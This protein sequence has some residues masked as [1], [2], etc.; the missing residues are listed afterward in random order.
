YQ[1]NAPTR[2]FFN[3]RSEDD[4]HSMELLCLRFQEMF[5]EMDDNE[6]KY[7]LTK[8]IEDLLTDESPKRQ[9]Y[10][11]TIDRIVEDAYRAGVI[12]ALLMMTCQL[13]TC[14]F[15]LKHPFDSSKLCRIKDNLRLLNYKGVRYFF[16]QLYEKMTFV[17]QEIS[18]AQREMLTPL[19][20]LLLHIMKRDSNV[21]PA[22][23]VA[24]EIN[25]MTRQRSL[26]FA[27]VMETAIQMEN[28]FRPLAEL[29]YVTARTYLF[30]IP[31]HPSFITTAPLWKLDPTCAF[32][33]HRLHLPFRI[34]LYSPQ[35]YALLMVMRQQKNKDAFLYQNMI[36]QTVASTGG[37]KAAL[38]N[39]ILFL[40]GDAMLYMER[41][42]SQS[43]NVS[44]VW[45]N[46]TLALHTLLHYQ[47]C[48]MNRF[49][50][51]LSKTVQKSGCRRAR[52]EVMWTL[53]QNISYL[54]R[55][56]P[57][58]KAS[59]AAI[60]EIYSYL[61]DKEESSVTSS[62]CPLKMVRSLSP[63][64]LWIDLTGGNESLPPP[65]AFLARQIEFITKRDPSEVPTDAMLAVIVNA[66]IKD[67]TQRLE[68]KT[69]MD[70]LISQLNAE[71]VFYPGEHKTIAHYV[72]F[73]YELLA[74]LG[75]KG[76]VAM[77]QQLLQDMK[78][79]TNDPNC[80]LPSP[81]MIETAARLSCLL[82]SDRTLGS[83]FARFV[84]EQRVD[85]SNFRFMYI[86]T[87][88][89]TFRCFNQ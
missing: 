45:D 29:S 78:A 59:L 39:I 67:G 26:M 46:I 80:A 7:W 13:N 84:D 2:M 36:K 23:F 15:T 66:F 28:T 65:S 5:S 48:D 76:Q 33:T 40:M 34:E 50:A 35:F 4:E 81:A 6:K 85:G 79:M 89:M 55:S 68:W 16:K 44:I 12:T 52:D 20:E 73:K 69:A 31:A 22:L 87:E 83:I 11:K 74:A 37:G 62:D 86:L 88:M 53:L 49:L 30:P 58:F 10:E 38:D 1:E 51:V 18:P 56:G 24:T 17:P 82:E 41:F 63:A 8:I 64:C 70:S 47:W 25:N 9:I 60:A 43:E 71:G 14:D 19:E 61:Y 54:Q 32:I 77:L 57:S 42:P 21:I 3:Q 75:L 72:P 27:R